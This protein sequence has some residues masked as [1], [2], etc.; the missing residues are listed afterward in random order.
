[1]LDAHGLSPAWKSEHSTAG[2]LRAL[3]QGMKKGGAPK[4]PALSRVA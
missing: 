3:I 1:M 2:R 4:R